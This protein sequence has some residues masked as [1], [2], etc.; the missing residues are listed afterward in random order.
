MFTAG[1]RYARL[2]CQQGTDLQMDMV[3]E[4]VFFY[5]LRAWIRV[6]SQHIIS[7]YTA[8]IDICYKIL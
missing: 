1:G 7:C 3:C 4:A 5:A 2:S 8:D 6:L